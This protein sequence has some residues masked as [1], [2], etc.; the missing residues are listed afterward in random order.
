MT[1]DE[2]ER[3]TAV[4]ESIATRTFVQLADTLVVDFDLIPLFRNEWSVIGSRTGTVRET[5]LV[6]TLI[7]AG[8]LTPR[9]HATP[10]LSEAAEAQRMIEE[11]EHFG[12]VI[13]RP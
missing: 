7:A 8:K 1:I 11:R 9:I 4:R 2:P 5:E 10:P 3:S 6:M 12:K 13:L